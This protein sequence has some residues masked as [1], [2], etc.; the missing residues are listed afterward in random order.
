VSTAERWRREA[1]GSDRDD[2]IREPTDRDI[3]KMIALMIAEAK[4]K[5]LAQIVELTEVD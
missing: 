1:I 5:Q 2:T 4:A 3:A